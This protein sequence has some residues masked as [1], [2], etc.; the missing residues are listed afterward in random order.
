MYTKWQSTK[1]TVQGRILMND[2]V[3]SFLLIFWQNKYK[4]LTKYW[5]IFFKNR[6]QSLK[7]SKTYSFEYKGYKALILFTKNA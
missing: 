2:F 7:I 6:F 4:N 5:T 1:Y 3:E